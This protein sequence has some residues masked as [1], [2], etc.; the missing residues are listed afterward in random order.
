[1]THLATCKF[2]W[3][4]CG[5]TSAT[6]PTGQPWNAWPTP[7]PRRADRDSWARGP[8]LA[9]WPGGCSAG[10]RAFLL[11]LR[12]QRALRYLLG[13]NGFVSILAWC[14]AVA[15]HPDSRATLVAAAALRL[16]RPLRIGIRASWIPGRSP[17]TGGG[18]E[19]EPGLVRGAYAPCE[20]TVSHQ[21]SIALA[22]GSTCLR[23]KKKPS[24]RI[25]AADQDGSARWRTG[26]AGTDDRTSRLLPLYLAS[27]V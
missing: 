16:S 24:E 18:G 10:A 26:R 13:T 22:L 8:G 9:Y 19:S 5:S 20:R 3:P 11:S 7:T 25:A 17:A 21:D 4:A 23:P 14:A 1:M 6:S 15:G 12:T 2:A 27:S